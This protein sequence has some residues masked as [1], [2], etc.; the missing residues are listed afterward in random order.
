ME[1]DTEASFVDEWAE[2]DKNF[3]VA[4]QYLYDEYKQWCDRNGFRAKNVNQAAKE[5]ERLG[6]ERKRTDKGSQWMGLRK[7]LDDPRE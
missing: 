1:N 3:Y 2:L 6:F 7:K 4:G 5:W